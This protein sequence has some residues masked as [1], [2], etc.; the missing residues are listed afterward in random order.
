MK[1]PKIALVYDRVNKIGGAE[2]VLLAMHELWP[3]APL[4]TA[5][6]DSLRASWASVFR[7][8]PSFLQRMP[9]AKRHH[10]IYPWLTPL[11]FESFSFDD[12]DIV[13]SITSAEAKDI[14]T[15]PHTIHIC[16]CLTP[17]RYLWS[18][19][20]EYEKNPNI[21][22]P[23]VIASLGLSMWKPALKQ[24]DRIAASRPDFYIAISRVV[25]SRIQAYYNRSVTRVI[26][27]PVERIGERRTLAACGDYFLVVSRLVP[28]KRID[29]IVD[30]A[31]E[32]ALPLVIVGEGTEKKR[33]VGRAGP[34]V[35]FMGNVSDS[36]LASHYEGCLA[37]ISAASEDFGIVAVEAQSFGKPVISYKKSGV[38][39]IVIDG[40]TGLLYGEQSP[41]CLKDALKKFN[42]KCYDS[43][44]CKENAQRFSKERFRG[45]MK[46]TVEELYNTYTSKL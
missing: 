12:F 36:A 8:H 19:E 44:L 3:E 22:I 4:Y 10:E 31:N 42:P 41:A 15:K 9:F 32:L 40:K 23:N 43:V 30:A 26:Y 11:A 24:W 28:Y 16:Y 17:T 34:T 5:V 2:R 45:E 6:Y 25:A 7:V 37:L 35:R 33:L 20:A 13:I 39:E 27:P 38:N 46:E 21:G 18:G 14:I 29:Q 1:Q